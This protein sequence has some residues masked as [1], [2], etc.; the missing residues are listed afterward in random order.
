[1]AEGTITGPLNPVPAVPGNTETAPVGPAGGDPKVEHDRNTR[2]DDFEAYL[3]RQTIM[4]EERLQQSRVFDPAEE[5]GRE[6]VYL[7]PGETTP[8]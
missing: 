7:K 4:F 2:Q 6:S 5:I 1:M 8:T 3:N